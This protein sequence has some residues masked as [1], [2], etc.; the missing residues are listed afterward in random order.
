M[1]TLGIVYRKGSQC[2]VIPLRW[3]LTLLC[4][5]WCAIRKGATHTED[6]KGGMG[7]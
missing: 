3:L 7:K 1:K 6:H 2:V 5:L 4:E